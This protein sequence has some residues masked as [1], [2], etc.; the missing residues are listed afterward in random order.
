MPAFCNKEVFARLVVAD[1]AEVR[2]GLLLTVWVVWVEFG[3]A[4]RCSLLLLA[5]CDVLL[6]EFFESV[7]VSGHDLV[8]QGLKYLLAK[9]VVRHFKPAHWL[10]RPE[11]SFKERLAVVINL[12]GLAR[13]VTFEAYLENLEG[14]CAQ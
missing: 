14:L 6:D 9:G 4:L 8:V 10:S 12:Q 7:L 5:G 3:N 11:K 1:D 2:L 13:F